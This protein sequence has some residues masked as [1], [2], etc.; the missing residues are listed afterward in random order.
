MFPNKFPLLITTLKQLN[1]AALF[2][3]AVPFQML[4]Q[5][6]T[7]DATNEE[8]GEEGGG[9]GENAGEGGEERSG[10]RI[11]SVFSD[12]EKACFWINTYHLL[13]LHG[14]LLLGRPWDEE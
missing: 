4:G 12:R 5:D 7:V 2:L 11:N 6:F 13:L 1:A 9:S 3:N 14:C 10:R 8:E